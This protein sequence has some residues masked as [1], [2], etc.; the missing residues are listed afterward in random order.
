MKK[1]EE[2]QNEI[3]EEKQKTSQDTLWIVL[4]MA[5]RCSHPFLPFITEEL[6]QHLPGRRPEDALI[7][8][9]YPRPV[10]LFFSFFFFLFLIFCVSIFCDQIL[11]W[12][13]EKAERDMDLLNTIAREVRS[14]KSGL[15]YTSNVC[16]FVA[17]FTC[18]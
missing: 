2:K 18:V 13:D 15:G 11:N 9:P 3:S 6:W 4:D 8:Q 10:S 17:N 1:E 14:L 7:V 16:F 5:L 12:I